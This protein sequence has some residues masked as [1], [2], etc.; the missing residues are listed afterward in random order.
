MNDIG[1]I[2]MRKIIVSFILIIMMLG[3]TSLAFAANDPNVVVVNPEQYSTVYSDSLLVSVK[4][5]QPKTIKVAFYEE[6]Q[7]VKGV[8]TSI[9]VTNFNMATDYSKLTDLSSTLVYGVDTFNCTNNLSFYTK[10]IEKLTPGLYRLQINTVDNTGKVVFETT[11]NIIIRDK[12]SEPV[13][14]S[15]IF[16]DAQPSTMQLIQNFFK[17][18]F[19][20]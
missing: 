14:T 13:G 11:K 18:I 19:G 2:P 10:Q 17:S 4:V 12:Q 9:N 8:A 16:V 1:D 7:M 6:K 15:L 20:S 3:T 5:L